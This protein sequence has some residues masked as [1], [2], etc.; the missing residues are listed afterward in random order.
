MWEE[1]NE[2]CTVICLS[3]HRDGEHGILTAVSFLFCSGKGAPDLC[4]AR[5]KTHNENIYILQ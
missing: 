4:I 1:E 2:N 5:K 3:C